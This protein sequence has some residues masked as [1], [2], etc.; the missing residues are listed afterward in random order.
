MAIGP[1]VT[2]AER[3]RA[4]RLHPENL[5]AWETFHRGLWHLE[6][7]NPESNATAR[8]FFEQAIALDPRFAAPH[9]WVGH[10]YLNEYYHHRSRDNADAVRHAESHGFRA[11]ALDPNDSA[12]HTALAWTAAA[13][14]DVAGAIA[15]ADR[16]LAINPNNVDAHR[17]RSSVLIWA[18]RLEEARD[19]A[20]YCLRLSPRDARSWIT[21]HHLT[22]IYYLMHDYAAAAEMGWG[23]LDAKPTYVLPHRWLAAALGQLD[24]QAEAASVMRR[25]AELVAPLSFDEYARQRGPWLPREQ[26]D[27]LHEG[28]R[29]AGWAG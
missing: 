20:Q 29:R 27:H 16:A 19:E 15:R 25:A 22:L 21:L 18:D 4:A 26:L 7:I 3:L 1:A 28:L 5:G 17:C 14:G 6:Q 8:K 2:G 11:V 12:A 24:R 23:V 13:A 10:T 9:A